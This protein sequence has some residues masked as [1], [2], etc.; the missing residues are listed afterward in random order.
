LIKTL[1]LA[2]VLTCV[3]GWHCHENCD[4]APSVSRNLRWSGDDPSSNLSLREKLADF[5]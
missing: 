3:K 2:G 4:I 1:E 5:I